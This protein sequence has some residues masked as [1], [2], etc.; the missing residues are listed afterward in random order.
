MD[1]LSNHRT[2]PLPV[3]HSI[4]NHIEK[5]DGA[6][7]AGLIGKEGLLTTWI[8][9]LN[10]SY[11]RGRIVLIN[12]VD[13]DNS[14]IPILPGIINDLFKNLS[15]IERSNNLFRPG[16]PKEILSVL[17]YGLHKLIGRGHRDIEIVE[18]VVS[19]FALD[20]IEN[21]GVVHTEDAHI[22]APSSP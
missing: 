2:Q 16:I 4:A 9:T 5:I 21:I 1:R 18:L 11:L 20:E 10:L 17:F 22:R 12:P 15:G 3:D 7:I 14:R 13:E 19:F 6:K 8:G